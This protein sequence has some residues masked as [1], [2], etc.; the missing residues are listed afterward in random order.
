MAELAWA[1]EGVYCLRNTSVP[2]V[3]R[4]RSISSPLRTLPLGVR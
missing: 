4:R 1:A 2:G 3:T